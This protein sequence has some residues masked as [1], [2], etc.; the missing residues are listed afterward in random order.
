MIYSVGT[1]TIVTVLGR[2]SHSGTRILA[3]LSVKEIQSWASHT[4][5]WGVT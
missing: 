4:S 5:K 2:Q 1:Q 3:V